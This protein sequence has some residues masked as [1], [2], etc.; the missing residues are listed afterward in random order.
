MQRSVKHVA[1][2]ADFHLLLPVAMRVPL[3]KRTVDEPAESAQLEFP[4]RALAFLFIGT[5]LDLPAHFTMIF[6]IDLAGS[7]K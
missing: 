7:Q 5:M 3:A 4:R 6:R 2:P 1:G